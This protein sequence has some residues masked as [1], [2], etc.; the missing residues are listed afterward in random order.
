M[1]HGSGLWTASPPGHLERVNDDLRGD[2][3][4]DRPTDDA[5]TE[6]VDNRG[7]VD[8][9]ISRAMLGDVA[10]PQPV[11]LGRAELALHEIRV[12]RRVGLPASPF[13]LMRHPCEAVEA[14]ES[15][16]A[17]LADVNAEPEPQFGEHPRGAIGATRV[18]VN[19]PDRGRERC[20][21][22]RTR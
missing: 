3:V 6:R 10:E 7:A 20:I 15:G 18:E 12:R 5:A 8:P 2:P 4:G 17:L 16:D 1:N 19:L 21:S 22:D 13:A 14:H 9:S 11:R